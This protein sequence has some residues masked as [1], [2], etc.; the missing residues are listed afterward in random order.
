MVNQ[1]IAVIGLG[2]IGSAFLRQMLQRNGKGIVIV[3]AAE[4]Y[5]T[6]GKREAEQAGIAL[7]TLDEI[8][9]SADAIDVLFDLTG[10][11]TVRRELREKLAASG[12]NHTVIASETIARVIWALI[13]DERLPVIEGR[14]TGY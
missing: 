4:P 5:D 1:R 2:R 10:I 7:K 3:C 13:T 12:N 6:P 14:P 9:A 11:A 8:V